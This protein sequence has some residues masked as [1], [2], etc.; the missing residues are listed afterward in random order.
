[1]VTVSAIRVGSPIPAEVTQRSELCSNF[2]YSD[3]Y[4]GCVQGHE[5][6]YKQERYHD[7][8]KFE[9]LGFLSLLLITIGFAIS[10]I[11][12]LPVPEFRESSSAIRRERERLRKLRQSVLQYQVGLGGLDV[13][14]AYFTLFAFQRNLLRQDPPF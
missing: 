4:N 3:G 10:D 7:H 6:C 14:F 9:P 1:M 8:D 13:A 12:I 5:A 11:A 2:W